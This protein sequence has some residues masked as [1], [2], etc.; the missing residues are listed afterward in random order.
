[1]WGTLLGDRGPFI[2][3]NTPKISQ[4]TFENNQKKVALKGRGGKEVFKKR[5]RK[6]TLDL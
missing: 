2:R 6:L 4:N 3:S 5:I 1:M